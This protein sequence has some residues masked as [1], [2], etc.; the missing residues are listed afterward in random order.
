MRR[1]LLL[2]ALALLPRPAR[3][4][5]VD[6]QLTVAMGDVS[7]LRKNYLAAATV[8]PPDLATA[9][10]MPSLEV[11]VTPKRVGEGLVFLHEEGRLEVLRLVATAPGAPPP[12]T[13]PPF[14][15]N[16]ARAACPRVEEKVVEGE[17]FL[18]ADV[19]T[20]Q[21]RDALLLALA[22]GPYDAGHL[23]LTFS[24]PAL[25]AQLAAMLERLRAAG[26]SGLELAYAGATLTLRGNVDAA[27]RQRG[28][29]AIWPVTL[30]RMDLDDQTNSNAEDGW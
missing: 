5:P 18:S 11:V 4:L 6:G 17:R 30:G 8:A 7:F 1:L 15:L 20:P 26:V 27:T 14:E 2:G 10:R 22:H 13:A 9:E 23:R 28:L 25:H 29:E 3:A 21:C 24:V 16:R 12:A 19:P